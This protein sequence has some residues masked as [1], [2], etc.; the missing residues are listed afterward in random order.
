MVLLQQAWPSITHF[1]PSFLVTQV[2][3]QVR[4]NFGALPYIYGT[5]VSA[6]LAL[7]IAVPVGIGVALFLAEPGQPGIRSVKQPI[8]IA[9]RTASGSRSGS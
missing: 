9:P 6:A 1:G 4:L 8:P 3:D 5:V 7:L 2:W